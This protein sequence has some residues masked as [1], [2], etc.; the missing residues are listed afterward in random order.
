MFEK[1]AGYDPLKK[2]LSTILG[3]YTDKTLPENTKL[4]RGVLLYGEPGTGKTLFLRSI[5]EAAPLPVYSF[6]DTGE[7][8]IIADLQTLF[9]KA[10]KEP[11]GA[12][13]II[14]EL[15]SLIRDAYRLQR[16][17]KEWMDGLVTH[18]RILVLASANSTDRMDEALFRPGR[19]DRKICMGSSSKAD[20][21]TI[22][23]YYLLQHGQSLP[24]E[25][26]DYLSSLMSS[27]QPADIVAVIEDAYLRNSGQP[28]TCESLETS[29][30]LIHY[31]EYL[32]TENA[33]KRTQILCVH[34]IGHAVMTDHYRS[35]FSVHLVSVASMV[36]RSG[37]CYY[38]PSENPLHTLDHIVERIE[39]MLAGR[40]ATK[41]ILGVNDAGSARDLLNARFEARRLVN[42]YG[43]CGI[44]HVLREYGKFERNESWLT[45]F[46]NERKATRI[47]RQCE[48]HAKRII[49]ENKAKILQLAAE[50]QQNGY[51]RG[52]RIREVM[53]AGKSHAIEQQNTTGKIP[54]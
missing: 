17:L 24:D 51:L 27:C 1:I 20:R 41:V 45:C 14:D 10:I 52:K 16:S 35:H 4:P 50:L 2:E 23:S 47:L 12:I 9:E 11:D 13:V 37:T 49:K 33:E 19:F 46:F 40:L 34:E 6:E 38:S 25:E 21:R 43:Y 28:I 8:N 18:N 36:D 48:K 29:H 5:Q 26:L 32:S 54:A 15:D 53:D 30:R 44:N 7:D 42:S 39:I 31:E 3:W 22:I